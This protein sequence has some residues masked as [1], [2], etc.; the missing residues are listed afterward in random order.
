MRALTDQ[1]HTLAER[2]E[3]R[4]V[5]DRAK[6]RLMDENGLSEAEA[7]GFI[8]KEAMSGRRSML[9]VANEILAQTSLSATS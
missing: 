7:F 8:Q 3:A 1:A 9:E 6:G 4:K 5:L 2:L